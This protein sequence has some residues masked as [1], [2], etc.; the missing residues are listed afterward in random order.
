MIKTID[1]SSGTRKIDFDPDEK[2]PYFYTSNEY[3]WIKN[4]SAD[5][6]YVSLSE[7]CGNGV[8]GTA[9]IAPYDAYMLILD[10]RNAFYAAGSGSI[11]VHTSDISTCPFKLSQKGGDISAE[12]DSVQLGGLQG[13]VPF[14]EVTVSGENIVG[15]ELTIGAG[16]E[17]FVKFSLEELKEY[18][19]WGTWDDN[20][21]TIKGV[22][23][24]VNND[25]T[26]TISGTA[27]DDILFSI[28]NSTTG[29]LLA[30]SAGGSYIVS[31][32]TTEGSE[33]T[34]YCYI[35]NVSTNTYYTSYSAAPVVI[36]PSESGN[37]AYNIR[38][39]KDAVLD[40]VVFKPFVSEG[41]IFTVTPDSNPYTV[42][43]E[44]YQQDGIN[45]IYVTGE[46]E[47]ALSVKGVKTNAAVKKIWDKLNELTTAIIVSNTGF[48]V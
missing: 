44:I 6:V 20:V 11:E 18:L 28:C 37:W 22:T 33:S 40:N 45:T 25:N 24:T 30:L 7:D 4:L 35:N 48:N 43:T 39:K 10:S 47:P 27:T 21:Y 19:V 41:N 3:V 9:A 13:G 31:G 42:P 16:N 23:L 5:T 34:Y 36:T 32:Q 1:L 14:S 2:S 8:D 17:N 15:Q 46:G 38:V 12:G 29:N 26:L